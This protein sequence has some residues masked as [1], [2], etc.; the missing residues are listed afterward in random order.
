MMITILWAF[1]VQMDHLILARRPELVFIN[2]KTRICHPVDF[3]IPED[4]RVKIKE[5][6]RIDKYV[7]LDRVLKKQW[8]MRRT[9]VPIGV[10]ALGAVLKSLR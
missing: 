4:H 9:V 2:K 1:R 10:C 6:K 8:N 5:S 7:D 3:T